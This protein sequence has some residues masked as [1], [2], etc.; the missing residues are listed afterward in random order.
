MRS[1]HRLRYWIPSQLPHLPRLQHAESLMRYTGR[2]Q[3]LDE[4]R[5]RGVDRLVGQLERAVVMGER[6]LGA[7]IDQRLDRRRE[8][9]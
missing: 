9:L 8:S 2:R 5:A 6:K 3:R 1:M 7:A 4:R